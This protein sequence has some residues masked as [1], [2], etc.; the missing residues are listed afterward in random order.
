[1]HQRLDILGEAAATIATPGIQEL[2]ADA[3]V[4][5]DALA[6]AVDISPYPFAEVGNVVHERDTGGEHGI[7]RILGHLG[8]GDIH[9]DDTEV[10]DEERLIETGHHLAGLLAL[11]THHDTVGRHEVLDGSTLFQELRVRGH[12]ERHL[13]AAP[14]QLLLDGGLHFLGSSDGN[15][16]LGDQDGVFVDMLSE[17]ASHRQHIF[18]VGR[19]ILVGRCPHGGENHLDIVE[20]LGEVGSELQAFKLHV[21]L[22]ELFQARLVDRH[23]TVL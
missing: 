15:R 23:D 21:T 13:N 20:H 18:Q 2:R 4:G 12:V 14:V 6:D 1:M 17:L 19:A 5:A 11:R 16:R 22:D 10:V 9:E 8:R 3:R 7:S